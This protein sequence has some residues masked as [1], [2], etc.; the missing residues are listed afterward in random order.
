MVVS[1]SGIYLSV[2]H[3]AHQGLISSHT[4]RL[5]RENVMMQGRDMAREKPLCLM[6]MYMKVAMRKDSVMGR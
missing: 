1:I 3:E 2:A 5:M 4:C 6:E